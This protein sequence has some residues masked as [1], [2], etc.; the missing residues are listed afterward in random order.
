M[1]DTATKTLILEHPSQPA[2]RGI[3][4]LFK[5]F[6]PPADAID[7]D[8]DDDTA[9]THSNEGTPTMSE[10]TQGDAAGLSYGLNTETKVDDVLAESTSRDLMVDPKSTPAS[11]RLHIG[12]RF[13]MVLVAMVVVL[14]VVFGLGSQVPGSHIGRQE[15][16]PTTIAA[17]PEATID[18]KMETPP[19][20]KVV[21]KVEVHL[22]DPSIGSNAKAEA[23][24]RELKALV[25][26]IK[27]KTY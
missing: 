9:S 6:C 5:G 13:E 8:D 18:A 20:T 15:T 27:T 22:D 23:R 17:I 2:F 7:D 11:S 19:E 24:L 1:D 3:Q 14:A 21:D 10:D 25:A 12:R 16:N 26:G 4:K